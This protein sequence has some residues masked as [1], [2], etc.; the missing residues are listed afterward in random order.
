MD[1]SAKQ[2][3]RPASEY[4]SV[5]P[6]ENEVKH[7]TEVDAK[8]HRKE[9]RHPETPPFIPQRIDKGYTRKADRIGK[10]LMKPDGCEFLPSGMCIL[11]MPKK[12]RKKYMW[13]VPDELKNDP[14]YDKEPEECKTDICKMK[15]E[16]RE[17]DEKKEKKQKKD[18]EDIIK[19][20]AQQI[21]ALIAHT[22]ALTEAVNNIIAAQSKAKD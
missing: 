19:Q 5:E 11:D 6:I 20:Q 16:E 21:A 8:S 2:S 13:L 14:M 9:I 17:N 12:D 10:P 7:S 3:A 1:I 22:T 18:Q 4:D 15:R